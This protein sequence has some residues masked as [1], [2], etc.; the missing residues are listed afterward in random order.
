MGIGSNATYT[1]PATGQ[2]KYIGLAADI[3][4]NL[5]VR[6]SSVPFDMTTSMVTSPMTASGASADQTSQN[7]RGLQLFIDITAVS[8]TL[9]TVTFFIEGKDP[10]SGKYVT[11]LQS[12]TISAVGTFLLTVY[13][14]AIAINNLL[15]NQPISKT[16]RVRWLVTGSSPSFTGT[17]GGSLMV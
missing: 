14:G 2:Q 7:C 16:W 8:G 1:D 9:P 6:G 5:L 11:L 13:P 15:A 10:V 12:A 3:N 4:G 17:V